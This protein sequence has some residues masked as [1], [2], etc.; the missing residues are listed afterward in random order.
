[1]CRNFPLPRK[2]K[3]KIQK[4]IRNFSGYIVTAGSTHKG[5]EEFIISS[6][7]KSD[8]RLIF[9]APRHPERFNEVSDIL[10]RSGL[11]WS[12]FS[13]INE[14]TNEEVIL[15][16]EVGSL[17]ELY[18]N[19]N[20][21]IVAGSICYEKGHNILE[22]IFAGTPAITGNKLENYREIKFLTNIEN[23]QRFEP[24]L[25]WEDNA[26]LGKARQLLWPVKQKYPKISWA[27]LI[28]LTG[29]VA[30]KR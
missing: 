10:S 24:E 27:D 29:N 11:K 19:S 2:S 14:I 9:L 6:I 25:S 26:N 17:F 15:Y 23:E 22:P 30:I 28:V 18:V 7:N 4:K 5:E 3:N 13:K 20:L 1:M 21:A 16:D 12:K 8:N